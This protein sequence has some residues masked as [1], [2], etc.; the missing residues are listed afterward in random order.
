MRLTLL[1]IAGIAVAFVVCVAFMAMVPSWIA[2]ARAARQEG[3]ASA[4][5]VLE[6]I[7]RAVVAAT[8]NRVVDV[9]KDPTKP[10][11]WTAAEAERVKRDVLAAVLAQLP[12]PTRALLASARVDVPTQ[13]DA[14]IELAVR[15]YKTPPRA[16]LPPTSEPPA[17]MH[18]TPTES[19]RAKR[20]SGELPAIPPPPRVP[21]GGLDR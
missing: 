13:A 6:R 4:L 11:V 3:I 15:E 16:D 12:D 17:T 21:T 7:A 19:P 18:D 5:V 20:R 9:L 8:M 14:T 2:R 10:G 1:T